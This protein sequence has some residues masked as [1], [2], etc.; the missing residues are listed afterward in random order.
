MPRQIEYEGRTIE[1]PDDFS[2]DEVSQV[3]APQPTEKLGPPNPPPTPE[4]T[5]WDALRDTLSSAPG[6]A[7]EALQYPGNKM[8][9]VTGA[10]QKLG[11]LMASGARKAGDPGVMPWGQARWQAP[12]QKPEERPQALPVTPEQ[13]AQSEERLRSVGEFAGR[14]AVDPLTYTGPIVK[15]IKGVV[16]QVRAVKGYQDLAGRYADILRNKSPEV[17]ELAPPTGP[18]SPRPSVDPAATAPPG[19]AAP[20]PRYRYGPGGLVPLAGVAAAVPFL[21]GLMK[22]RQGQP[23][24]P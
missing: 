15:G 18:T 11:A 23:T 20:K 14:Q 13:Q 2:D 19:S 10:G 24:Q 6:R 16:G 7:L 12:W 5:G 22:R 21:E 1:V 3:L 17:G 8:E 4:P 9:E